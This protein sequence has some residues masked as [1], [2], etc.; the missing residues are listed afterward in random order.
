MQSLS[1]RHA[2]ISLIVFAVMQPFSALSVSKNTLHSPKRVE[3]TQNDLFETKNW[4][5]SLVDVLGFHLGMTRQGAN[6]NARAQ[7]LKL[8]IPDLRGSATC[9]GEKCEVCDANVVCPGIMLDFSSDDRVIGVEVSK[10]PEDGA[11]VVR[12]AAVTNRFKGKTR[13]LFS[14]Y[15]NNLRLEL[16]GKEA[17]RESPSDKNPLYQRMV[18]YKY[19]RL[20]IKIFVSPNQHGPEWTADLVVSFVPPQL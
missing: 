3:L 4:D 20:G 15:S 2:A 17:S 19:P 9:S 11:E 7:D 16:L 10:I 1:L 8:V 18:T 6:V 5:S 13:L 14:R 12:K